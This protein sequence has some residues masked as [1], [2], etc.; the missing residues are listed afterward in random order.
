MLD[1]SVGFGKPTNIVAL[2]VEFSLQTGGSRTFSE[3]TKIVA[4]MVEFS[5]QT[6]AS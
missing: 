2:L 1:S 3:A 6:G 5:L 4:F